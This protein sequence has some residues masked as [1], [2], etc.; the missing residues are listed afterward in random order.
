M[1]VEFVFKIPLLDAFD[2]GLRAHWHEYGSFDDAVRGVDAAGTSAGVGALGDEF[3]LH[4]FTVRVI[5]SGGRVV[6]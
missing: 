4:Y 6:S 1:G 3:K 5:A 2:C